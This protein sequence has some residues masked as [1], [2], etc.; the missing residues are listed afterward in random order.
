VGQHIDHAW[1]CLGRTGVDAGDATLGDGR[2]DHARVSEAGH[3]E[4]AGI[5]GG[6]GNL[7]DPVDT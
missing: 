4:L 1:N 7:R 3:V 5:F 6:T 2:A